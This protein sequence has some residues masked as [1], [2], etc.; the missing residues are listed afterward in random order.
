MEHL[1]TKEKKMIELCEVD[2]MGQ[3]QLCNLFNRFSE[4]ATINALKIQLWDKDMM[5]DYGWVVAKQT[6][7]LD[8]PIYLNDEIELMTIA[9]KNTMVSFPRYYFISKEGKQI[10]YCSS[11]WTL[12]DMKKRRI[13]APKR[14]G[15]T[16]P[17]I[18]H[19]LTL[20]EPKNI[21][22][23]IPM[24]YIQTRQVCYSDV[25]TNQHMNNTRYIQWALD[26]IDY[27]IHK[28][29]FISDIT[30]Q[31]KKEI[32]PLENVE[33]FLGNNGLRYI[34]EGKSGDKEFFLI[35]IDFM[36]R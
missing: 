36:K 20:E 5:H 17:I 26:I 22:I 10:G 31:Y 30:I 8:K 4:I 25:D 34:V 35:E 11:I 15:M 33:L 27:H 9:G 28:D 3:Y 29:Y 23:N 16:V 12:I 24:T 13:V 14:I 2:Y 21:D 18:N 1:M 19:N 7:H 32:Q 6:L